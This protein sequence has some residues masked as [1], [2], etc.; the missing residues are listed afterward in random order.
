MRKEVGL[1]L[2]RESDWFRFQ[3][4]QWLRIDIKQVL[5]DAVGSIQPASRRRQHAFEK[6]NEC[7]G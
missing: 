7:P 5:T 6:F 2:F 3:F 1:G 4:F